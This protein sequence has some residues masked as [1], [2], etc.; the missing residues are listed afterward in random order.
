MPAMARAFV[1]PAW[2][3]LRPSV[4]DYLLLLAGVALS[5]YLIEIAPLRVEATDTP[6]GTPARYVVEFLARPLRLTEGVVLLGPLLWLTQ[7]LRGRRQPLT[8]AEWLWG[9]SWVGIGLLT[10]LA[11]WQTSGTMPEALAEWAD[12]PR[13]LWYVVFVPATAALAVVL[14]LAGLLRRGPPP[15]THS[16]AVALVLWPVAPLAGILALGRFA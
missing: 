4:V 11:C 2:P 15:W 14:G 1:P 10:G 8:A 12:L 5:L 16:L 9:V 7:R 3:P 13:R 6:A